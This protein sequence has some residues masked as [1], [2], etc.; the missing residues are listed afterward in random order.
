MAHGAA[1]AKELPRAAALQKENSRWGLP[2]LPANVAA[3]V[4]AH[5]HKAALGATLGATPLAGSRRRTRS[6]TPAAP[7]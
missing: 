3:N 5:V 1:V 6:A 7:T 2:Q 4:A